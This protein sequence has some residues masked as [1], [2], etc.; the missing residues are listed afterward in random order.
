MLSPPNYN[1][2]LVRSTKFPRIGRSPTDIEELPVFFDGNASVNNEE[3]DDSRW[4]E[5]RSVLFPRIG[6]R[7]FRHSLGAGSFTRAYPML[8]GQNRFYVNGDADRLQQGP[9]QAIFHSRDKRNIPM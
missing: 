3:N 4:F 1:S 2:R 7:A 6:K 5:Q 8:D 9:L